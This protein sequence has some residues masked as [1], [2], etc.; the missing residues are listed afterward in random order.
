MGRQPIITATSVRR[1]GMTNSSSLRGS[2]FRAPHAHQTTNNIYFKNLLGKQF[3]LS[4]DVKHFRGI[5]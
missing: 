3:S 5:H 1:T 2:S 4:E